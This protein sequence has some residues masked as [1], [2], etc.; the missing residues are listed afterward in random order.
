MATYND[1]GPAF[2]IPQGEHQQGDLPA[3]GM[4]LLD[5]HAGQVANG[6]FSSPYAVDPNKY[7]NVAEHVYDMAQE[8]VNESLK[9]AAQHAKG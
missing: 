8:L 7:P 4:S 6:W 5:Y 3:P 9:R 2:P 1:G